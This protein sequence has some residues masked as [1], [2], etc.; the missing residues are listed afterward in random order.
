VTAIQ[1]F[2][3]LFSFWLAKLF[4]LSWHFEADDAKMNNSL[5]DGM[6]LQC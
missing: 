2:P 1:G 5:D 3:L 4:G 6:F